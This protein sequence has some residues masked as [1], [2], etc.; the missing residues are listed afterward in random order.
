[1]CA[2]RRIASQLDACKPLRS[3]APSFPAVSKW[4]LFREARLTPTAVGK[5][6][7]SRIRKAGLNAEGFSG[8]SMRA[9]FITEARNAGATDDEIMNQTGHNSAATLRIYDREYAPL[10]RNASTRIKL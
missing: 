3:K 1:M 5:V 9:G 2:A 6:V 10:V 8:H 4:G 7:Q